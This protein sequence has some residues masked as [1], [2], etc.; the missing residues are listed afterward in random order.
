MRTEQVIAEA[1][2]KV[3]S[4]R[5]LLSIMVSKRAEQLAN[6]AQPLVKASTDKEKFTDIALKEIAEGQIILDSI[7]D[8][9]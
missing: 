2:K 7:I 9:K 3:D 5:Y 8:L 1:L 6:G 4:D